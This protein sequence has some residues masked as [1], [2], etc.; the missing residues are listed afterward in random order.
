MDRPPPSKQNPVVVEGL[1]PSG[2]S[3]FDFQ[4]PADFALL[5]LT[6]GLEQHLRILLEGRVCKNSWEVVHYDDLD[7]I[8]LV[9]KEPM[10]VVYD[11][12]LVSAEA[13]SRL[14]SERGWSISIIQP[15][16]KMRLEKRSRQ[17]A[18]REFAIGCVAVA[19]VIAAI[20]YSLWRMLEHPF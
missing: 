2:P 8:P 19:L 13:I 17:P 5:I 11:S 7:S 3:G 12:D 20:L 16:D 15:V 10:I 14:G 9:Q 1:W 6:V 4:F 18:A